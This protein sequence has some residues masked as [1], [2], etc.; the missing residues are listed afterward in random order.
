[1]VLKHMRGHAETT[2][3]SEVAAK[4]RGNEGLKE[5]PGSQAWRSSEVLSLH[6]RR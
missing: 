6:P 3:P 5:V 1:M 4:V 2:W